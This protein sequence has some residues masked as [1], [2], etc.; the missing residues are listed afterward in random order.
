MIISTKRNSLWKRNPK[1]L[2]RWLNATRN[3][4]FSVFYTCCYPRQARRRAGSKRPMINRS[5]KV[6]GLVQIRERPKSAQVFLADK[7]FAEC[8]FWPK[9]WYTQKKVSYSDLDQILLYP[10]SATVIMGRIT[11]AQ[12]R[13]YYASTQCSSRRSGDLSD[14]AYIL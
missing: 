6:H 5:S 14:S 11:A 12:R 1:M 13:N 7:Y 3:L 10:S 9:I 8:T 4:F 2:K